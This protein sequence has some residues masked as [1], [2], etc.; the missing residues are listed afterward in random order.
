MTGPRG[1]QHSWV[2]VR[3]GPLAPEERAVLAS[4]RLAAEADHHDLVTVLL[5]TASYDAESSDP[6]VAR[7]GEEWVLEDDANGRGIRR[8]TGRPG[9]TV[10]Y[11]ELVEAIMTAERVIQLP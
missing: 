4:L 3:Q 10:S 8:S 7:S 9:R 11:D 1:E 6:A 5:G 2:L